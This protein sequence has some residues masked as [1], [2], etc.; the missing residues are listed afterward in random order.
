MRALPFCLA[1]TLSFVALIGCAAEKAPRVEGGRE[2]TL[3]EVKG[4]E[5]SNPS[6]TAYRKFRFEKPLRGINSSEHYILEARFLNDG[7]KMIFHDHF[8]N[9]DKR[10]GVELTFERQGNSLNVKISTPGRVPVSLDTLADVFAQ[11]P[12]IRL[13][14]EL[15]DGVGAGTHAL[16]WLNDLN[17]ASPQALPL[18]VLTLSSATIDSE[19]LGFVSAASGR[20]IFAGVELW[21]VDLTS[22]RRD[23]PYV[24]E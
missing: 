6:P 1:L 7:S 8:M 22:A 3:I 19:K 14:L 24:L 9:F 11:G 21:S 17:Q 10:D 4:I 15:H 23:L 12:Y 16:I 5:V 20:G 2:E 13:R 18:D